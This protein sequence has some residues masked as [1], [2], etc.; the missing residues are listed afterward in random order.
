M[1]KKLVHPLDAWV[2]ARETS[3]YTLSRIV[4]I[5]FRALYRHVDPTNPVDPKASSI[6]AIEDATEGEVTAQAQIDWIRERNK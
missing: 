5:P 1:K 4:G 6:I 3:L 2:K